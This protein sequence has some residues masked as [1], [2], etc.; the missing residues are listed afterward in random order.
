MAFAGRALKLALTTDVFCHLLRRQSLELGVFYYSSIDAIEHQF[1]R[2]YAPEYF[3]GVTEE[4]VSHY[5]ELIPRIYEAA[6]AAIARILEAAEP[7]STV[8]IASDHGQQ[9]GALREAWYVI[10]TT[11]LV[12]ELALGDSVRATN[13]G[14]GVFMRPRAGRESEF[15]AAVARFETEIATADG[16]PVFRIERPA[17]HEALLKVHPDFAFGEHSQ[18]LIGGHTRDLDQIINDAPRVS[19]EHTDVALFLIAGKGV[20]SGKTLSGGSVLDIAP[21][22]LHSLG[23]PVSR[24]LEG[25][26]LIEAFQDP[27]AAQRSIAFVDSYGLP[28]RASE[29]GTLEEVK[30]ETL[31]K[32]RALGYVQ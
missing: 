13:V 4:E 24:E 30:E 7:G 28:A 5:G 6:D 20:A 19:G 31:E 10:R 25:R 16:G 2:Y 9:P 29:A 22:V 18:V 23:L 21:T 1:F 26:V 15:E 12:Q 17:A 8:V 32:L 14:R 3:P 27:G 11:A